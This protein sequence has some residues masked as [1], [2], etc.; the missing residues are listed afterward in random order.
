MKKF[1]ALFLMIILT[2]SCS[3]DDGTNFH[4]AAMPITGVEVPESF[5]QGET[6]EIK[7]KYMRPT[8]CYFFEGFDYRIGTDNTRTVVV[9]NTVLDDN[10]CEELEDEEVEVSFDF[11][12]LDTKT[13]TFRF[14]QGYD[15]NGQSEFLTVEVPVE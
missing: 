15:D 7:V 1:L 13:Y 11:I 14:W 9:I 3:L 6:Y 12:V 2:A 5:E 8:N 4:F 10:T